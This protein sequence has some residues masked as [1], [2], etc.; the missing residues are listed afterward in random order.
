MGKRDVP[1]L[2]LVVHVDVRDLHKL[3]E[4]AKDL[5]GHSEF[6]VV[7]SNSVLGVPLD[8]VFHYREKEDG[9]ST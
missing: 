7:G 3:F 8:D 5:S 2:A 6:V 4:R 1:E 9:R